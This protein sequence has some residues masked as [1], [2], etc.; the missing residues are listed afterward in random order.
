[1]Q[2]ATNPTR[3]IPRDIAAAW[4]LLLAFWRRALL[5]GIT[6][7]VVLL[8]LLGPG[9]L[10]VLQ[11][12]L[13]FTSAQ[14][15]VN[16][17]IK[18]LVLSVRGVLLLMLAALIISFVALVGLSGPALMAAA[19][20][21]GRT[22][23]LAS[24]RR[25]I[26][27]VFPRLASPA[28]LFFALL[29]A[30]AGPLLALLAG[31]LGSVLLLPFGG[32]LKTDDLPEVIANVPGVFALLAVGVLIGAY[33]FCRWCLVFPFLYL[34]QC[35]LRQ[36][37]RRSARTMR[38]H[39][40]YAGR[41]LLT[42]ELFSAIGVGAATLL[43]AGISYGALQTVDLDGAAFRWLLAFLMVVTALV[44]GA[45]VTLMVSRTM[46]LLTILYKRLRGEEAQSLGDIPDET[47]AGI[48]ARWVV[49]GVLVLIVAGTLLSLPEVNDELNKLDRRAK[50]TAHRGSS[51]EAPE[52]TLA[53]VR[54]AV[55]DRAD[56]AE[57]DIMQAKDGT[58][59]MLHDENLRRVAG[60][61]RNI[62]DLT[63]E[64]LDK[65][66][67]GSWHDEKYRGEP[68]VTLGEVLAFAHG[69]IKLNIE[70][71][72]H[73]R[74]DKNFARSALAV[75]NEHGF[76]DECVITSLDYG[77]LQ[78]IR[79]RQPMLRLGMIISA[80][81][82]RPERLDVDFYSTQPLIAKRKFIRSAHRADRQVH[83]W[84]LNTRKEINKALDDGAD[85][86]ITDVPRLAREVLDARTPADELKAAIVRLFKE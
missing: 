3:S 68:I 22:M 20:H 9:L 16:Y 69:K 25:R 79:R 32:S 70:L 28:V 33:L 48:R 49:A 83:V 19:A 67:V 34:E 56:Y 65:L 52:N 10:W 85:N 35:T 54:L 50:I 8:V 29:I 80:I 73:K 24:V 47:Q 15:V 72:V 31:F 17:D 4:R 77:I 7:E 46:A 2:A 59:V 57:I 18:G 42:N 26:W 36:A 39:Y 82:G 55:E 23:S 40:A 61:D 11:E 1:M 75:I 64:D 66:E 86:I 62:W 21:E 60:V 14:A 41:L 43:M 76:H 45:A 5:Y 74:E 12:A 78:E 37:M 6:F 84:T 63:K 30:V 38:G 51:I 27:N 58:L 71:K 13:A 53:A 44:V 81:V